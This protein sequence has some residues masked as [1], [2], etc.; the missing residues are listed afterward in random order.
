MSD[1]ENY[2]GQEAPTEEN[3]LPAYTPAPVPQPEPPKRGFGFLKGL[4]CVLFGIMLGVLCLAFYLAADG[5]LSYRVEPTAKEESATGRRHR[6]ETS[7]A[8]QPEDPSAQTAEPVAD[9]EPLLN[10]QTLKELA[11]IEAY[12][13]DYFFYE[14][15][16]QAMRDGLLQGVVRSLPDDYAYYYNEAEFQKLIE[17]DEGEYCGIG[18][19]VMQDG[20]TLQITVTKVFKGSPAL[21]AGILPGDI[22]TAVDGMNVQEMDL[23]TVVTYIRGEPGTTVDLTFFRPSENDYVDVTSGRAKIDTPSVEWEML[24]GQIGYI[25]LEQFI[26]NTYDQYVAALDDLTAQGMKGL[27]VDVR[28]DPGGLLDIVVD[29]CDEMVPEGLVISVRDRNGAEENYYSDASQRVSLPTVVITNGNTASAA[30]IFTANLQ[31]YGVATVIGTKTFGKGIVQTIIPLSGYKT[32]LKITTA[33]YYTPNGVCIHGEGIEPDIVVELDEE[34]QGQAI[35]PRELDNQ[36]QKAIEV[37]ED[38]LD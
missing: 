20:K 29:I 19:Q 38:M 16:R 24:D 4:V 36:L 6:S 5:R 15:D 10:E 14:Q 25:Q 28:D 1:F 9:D 31:D 8:T 26:E 22:L 23:N 11:D 18:V 27:I 3:G 32:A 35:I 34:A 21:E 2:G 13:D 12:I 37:I 7:E 33:E 17:E 30:E